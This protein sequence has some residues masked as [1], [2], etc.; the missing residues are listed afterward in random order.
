VAWADE[1]VVVDTMSADHTAEL[2]RAAGAKVIVR[3]DPGIRHQKQ[4]A[5]EQIQSDWILVLDPD[6]WLTIEVQSEI[7]E[8]LNADPQFCAYY[9]PRFHVFL[10]RVIRHGKGVDHPLRLLKRGAGAYVDRLPHEYIQ[11]TGSVGTLQNGMIHDS[12]PSI[13]RRI[14]KIQK[15]TALEMD[16]RP[17]RP[18]TLK[19]LFLNPI[20]YF[21]SM[22]FKQGGWRD[23][24][25][26]VILIG[27]F[28]VQLFIMHAKFY[29]A[30]ALDKPKN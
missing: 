18:P 3:A 14:E 7:Q 8:L 15:E 24:I 28:S 13:D 16:H 23:G 2:A 27:L 30:H 11:V 10:G 4:F 5:L 20:I 6:E 17:K 19:E 29:E 12:T 21:L 9:I 26:G 22:T 25:P 1:V